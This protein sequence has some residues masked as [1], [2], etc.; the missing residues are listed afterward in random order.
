MESKKSEPFFSANLPPEELEEILQQ[1]EDNLSTRP[2]LHKEGDAR[3]QGN[4]HTLPLPTESPNFLALVTE[5]RNARAPYYVVSGNFVTKVIKQVHNIVMKV[6]GRKQAY[7]NEL[8]IN[9]LQAMGTDLQGRQEYT[10]KQAL[11]VNMLAREIRA[12]RV[13]IA[14]LESEHEQ[15]LKKAKLKKRATT[16]KRRS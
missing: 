5:L 6:F 9:L 7:F 8:T 13:K 3:P 10:Q 2:L 1:I 14:A 15:L 16:P 11:L 4:L 12:Q